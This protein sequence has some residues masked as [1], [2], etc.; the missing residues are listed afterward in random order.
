MVY[1]DAVPLL[2]STHS[3]QFLGLIPLLACSL[4]LWK[5]R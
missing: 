3:S 4:S 2:E 1:V 5:R